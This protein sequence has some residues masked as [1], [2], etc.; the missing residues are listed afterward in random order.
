MYVQ[1]NAGYSLLACVPSIA[2]WPRRS[3][4]MAGGQIDTV[5]RFSGSDAKWNVSSLQE[6]QTAAKG[7]FRMKR[8]WDWVSI[9]KWAPGDCAY[10][11]DR[12]GRLLVA[13]RR[14]HMRWNAE[15]QTLSLP[16]NLFPPVLIARSLV[17]CTGQLPAL[18]HSSMRVSFGG[19][20][21]EMLRL[22]LSITGL[23][24]A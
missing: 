6:A 2:A 11:D 3:C 5:R 16:A 24:L 18:D 17:L 23:R 1:Q 4:Q 12:A 22:V 14:R 9:L 7:F 20:T 21:A 8:D 15:T 19:I 13:A 10:I